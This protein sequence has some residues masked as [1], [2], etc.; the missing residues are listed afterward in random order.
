MDPEYNDSEHDSD[1]ENG[2]SD[3]LRA[4]VGY[5]VRRVKR[6]TNRYNRHD[7]LTNTMLFSARQLLECVQYFLVRNMIELNN[8][9]FAARMIAL[10]KSVNNFSELS[11]KKLL[12]LWGSI[13]IMSSVMADFYIFQ[14]HCCYL[15]LGDILFYAQDGT[16]RN[17]SFS[18]AVGV[19]SV[20]S[21]LL[22]LRPASRALLLVCCVVFFIDVSLV[23]RVEQVL[24]QDRWGE[25]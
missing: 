22:F 10:F 1:V 18:F 25:V 2:D 6:R 7:S 20:G 3:D 24:H 11:K 21:L 5:H 13:L 8:Y 15:T 17:F 9:S 19:A 16:S 12:H 23:V 14:A 4:S